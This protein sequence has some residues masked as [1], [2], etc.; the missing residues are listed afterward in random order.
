VVVVV[1]EKS[2]RLVCSPDSHAVEREVN[3]ILKDNPQAEITFLHAL[4]GIYCDRSLRMDC[5]KCASKVVPAAGAFMCSSCKRPY[6]QEEF[7]QH[8]HTVFSMKGT[9]YLQPL[10][11]ERE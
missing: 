9:H 1:K 6:T 8:A 7:E 11:I 2:Y 5:P 3:Q 10:I 4:S